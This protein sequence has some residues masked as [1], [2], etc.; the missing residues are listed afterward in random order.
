MQIRLDI[1]PRLTFQLT[2]CERCGRK[3]HIHI[4]DITKICTSCDFDIFLQELD[5]VE[6][7]HAKD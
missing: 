7:A 2:T 1:P 4:S 5:A 3:E 6:K